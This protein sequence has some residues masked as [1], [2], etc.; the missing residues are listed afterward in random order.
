VYNI[1]FITYGKKPRK[2][3]VEM[4]RPKM[5][6]IA[7]PI[8]GDVENNC[9]RVL[10][11]CRQIHTK[12]VIPVFPRLTWSQYLG[13]S[14]DDKELAIALNEAYFRS[15]T[16]DELWVYGDKLS[17]GMKREIQLARELGIKVV[18]M[19]DLVAHDIAALQK[20]PEKRGRQ[21]LFLREDV[22]VS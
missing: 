16:I 8:S 22:G 18:P 3:V 11:I 13:D 19:T 4:S 21:V 5:V 20:E 14:P 12:E 17:D 7:H 1:A 2:R 15:G 10:E 9:R 6:F